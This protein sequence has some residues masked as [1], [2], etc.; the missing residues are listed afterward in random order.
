ML[1]C[2]HV[3]SQELVRV[4]RGIKIVVLVPLRKGWTKKVSGP[5]QFGYVSEIGQQ[6]LHISF[7]NFSKFAGCLCQNLLQSSFS[8]ARAVSESEG[9]RVVPRGHRGASPHS[10]CD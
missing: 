1:T 3:P 9:D 8:I 6:I 5:S 10:T 2:L 4:K 7:L